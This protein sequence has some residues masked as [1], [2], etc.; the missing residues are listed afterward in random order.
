MQ[1][2][3]MIDRMHSIGRV[4]KERRGLRAIPVTDRLITHLDPTCT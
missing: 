2:T 3:N 1:R 4:G